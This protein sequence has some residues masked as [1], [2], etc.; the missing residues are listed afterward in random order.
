MVEGTL[1]RRC[2]RRCCCWWWR[3]R[4]QRGRCLCCAPAGFGGGARHSRQ[5]RL[6][7]A[8]DL[9]GPR[10]ECAQHGRRKSL[11][12]A[13]Y[14]RE[15]GQTV[16]AQ[17]PLGR[18]PECTQIGRENIPMSVVRARARKVNAAR[19]L[20]LE[21]VQLSIVRARVGT[22]TATHALGSLNSYLILGNNRG[23]CLSTLSVV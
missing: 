18:C 6:A 5:R 3:S 23:S 13:S 9:L 8:E 4:L 7:H 20:D 22:D 21:K 2:V 12:R 16:H 15:S 11:N 17:G 10:L 19:L 1:V 14:I